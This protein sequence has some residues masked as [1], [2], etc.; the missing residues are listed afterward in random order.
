MTITQDAHLHKSMFDVKPAA[1]QGAPSVIS[2]SIVHMYAGQYSH[3]GFKR[4]TIWMHLAHLR[5]HDL[6][7]ISPQFHFPYSMLHCVML[8][9]FQPSTSLVLGFLTSR[10]LHTH[11]R[12]ILHSRVHAQYRS[13]LCFV[14]YTAYAVY[15]STFTLGRTCCTIL[16]HGAHAKLHH[17][18][19]PAIGY[20]AMLCYA[21][22][23]CHSTLDCVLHLESLT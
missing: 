11:N 7:S 8:L 3:N 19:P 12:C 22:A 9:A 21:I 6:A 4:V 23:C 15:S 13:V 16:C 1:T 14:L 17:L 20:H 5:F 2:I 18:H 10:R